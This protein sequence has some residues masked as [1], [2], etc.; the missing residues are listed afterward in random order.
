MNIVVQK[1][2]G[3][4]VEN[5]DKL[6]LVCANIISEINKGNKVVV[7]VSAQ[8]D[9]T[10]KLLD[11]T[12]SLTSSSNKRE[13]DVLLSVGE[14]ITISKLAILLNSLGYNAK[15]YLGWQI[16]IIT[17]SNY[18]NA[19]IL[20]IKTDRILSDLE[21]DNI[22]IVAGFQGID[23]DMN[24]TTLGRGGS[25]TTA[26]ALADALGT[27]ECYLYKDVDGVYTSDPNKDKNA[28]QIKNLS[29]AEMLKLSNNGAQVVQDKG[30]R[31]AKDRLVRIRVKSTFDTSKK[32]TII[33]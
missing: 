24:I 6:R 14:Q 1:Y 20:E 7:V 2:G 26:I 3:S 18:G 25:D 22:V 5:N 29:Y 11:E 12:K 33:C 19:D 17:N 10:D 4:S 13:M 15:S 21:N 16:P 8:G 27:N 31:M 9:T 30:V 28:K 32:G 23:K